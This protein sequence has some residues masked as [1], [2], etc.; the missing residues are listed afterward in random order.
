MEETV[1]K[2]ARFAPVDEAAL[3][4]AID[5]SVPE[6]T[7][8]ATDFWLG[9]FRSF[10]DQQGITIDLKKC[11]PSEFDAA[12][13][14]FYVGLRKKNGEM[15]RKS[16]YLAARAALSRY[17][18]KTLERPECN[19]FRKAEFQRSNVVLDRT[20]KQKKAEGNEPSVEHK[21]SIH[22]SDLAKLALYFYDV[23]EEG[24]TV[25]LTQYCWFNISLHFA[26]RGAEVQ[27]R[28]KKED[29]VFATDSEGKEYA[30]LRRDFL[31]K[32][33]PGG[34]G[35]REFETCG[36][37]QDPRKVQALKKLL[38]KLHL[39]WIVCFSEPCKVPK[40]TPMK[41]GSYGALWVT[42]CSEK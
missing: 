41:R 32:N 22:K 20:L 10:C 13:S 1:A 38:S 8:V 40:L 24:N 42:P 27:T 3:S 19:V 4:A 17:V 5:A 34:V 39:K 29:I 35:G 7:K 25:K 36:R 31:W 2:K 23:L 12:L 18:A 37:L 33:C 9:V 28:L 6:T 16:S 14:Q 30:T 21:E 11:S 26:L 15:Y